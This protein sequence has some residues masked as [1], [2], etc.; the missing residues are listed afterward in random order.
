MNQ[1]GETTLIRKQLERIFDGSFDLIKMGVSWKSELDIKKG[2][3]PW[4]R[5]YLDHSVPW[6][7]SLWSI[8]SNLSYYEKQRSSQVFSNPY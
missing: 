3:V 8:R 7:E 1:S 4:D 6:K 2:Y 5:L